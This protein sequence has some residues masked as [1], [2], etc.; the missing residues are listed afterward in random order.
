MLS[1]SDLHDALLLSYVSRRVGAETVHDHHRVHDHVH[2]MQVPLMALCGALQRA[3]ARSPSL[4]GGAACCPS[5]G[6]S[7]TRAERR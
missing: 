1:E 7:S 5:S 6:T 2:V 3:P 4:S